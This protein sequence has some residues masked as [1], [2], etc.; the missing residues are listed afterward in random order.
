[1]QI[2]ILKRDRYGDILSISR[3]GEIISVGTTINTREA[4]GAW[5]CCP[6]SEFRCGG[7]EVRAGWHM[8]AVSDIEVL[9]PYCHLSMKD[10]LITN[11]YSLEGAKNEKWDT[12]HLQ[13]S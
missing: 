13:K 8:M 11:P 2:E 9:Y 5:S 7:K 1:M 12:H 4:S 3:D 6:I 10:Y